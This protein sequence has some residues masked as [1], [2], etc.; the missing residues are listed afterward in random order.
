MM[1]TLF[2]LLLASS[3]IFPT[4]SWS[5]TGPASDLDPA[6]VT[7]CESCH[8]EHGNS[9]S[10]TVPRLN[11]Q[12]QDYLQ[13]RLKEFLDPTRG[14]P[15]ATYQMWET[16]TNLGDRTAAGLAG[17]FALQTPTPA[18]P[19]G[20]LAAKGEKIYLEGAGPEVPACASCHGSAGE[21]KGIVPRLA[22]QHAEYLAQQVSAFMLAIRVNETMNR[23]AWHLDGDQSKAIAA[24]LANGD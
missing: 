4:A 3:V 16:A 24:Y 10:P 22:G 5:A 2:P 11:G 15:H 6:L 20:A 18:A 7:K 23:H 14:T 9:T 19:K 21:G 8:G 13:L 1:K 17:Y 12:Q